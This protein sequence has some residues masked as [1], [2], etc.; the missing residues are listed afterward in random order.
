MKG[1]VGDR[2]DIRGKHVGEG[3][4]HGEIVA[5]HGFEGDPPSW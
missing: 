4:R 1:S 3:G 2:I 5:V